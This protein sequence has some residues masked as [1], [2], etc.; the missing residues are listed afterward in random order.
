M[1]ESL[2]E[3]RISCYRQ[4]SKESVDQ[5]EFPKSRLVTELFRGVLSMEDIEEFDHPR[6]LGRNK[7]KEQ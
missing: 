1:S 2:I 3:R 5:R 6:P 4:F 7:K